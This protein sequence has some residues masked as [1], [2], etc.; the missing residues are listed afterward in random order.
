MNNKIL[1]E[2]LTRCAESLTH[3]KISGF[4]LLFFFNV[5]LH[6]PSFCS[7]YRPSSNESL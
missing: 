6:L 7:K 5:Y 1:E 4:Y 3:S 2:E